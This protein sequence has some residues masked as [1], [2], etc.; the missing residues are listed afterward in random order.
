M[1]GRPLVNNPSANPSPTDSNRKT[2]GKVRDS[3]SF[4]S[5]LARPVARFSSG[6]DEGIGDFAL[7]GECRLQFGTAAL[8]PDVE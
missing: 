7:I 6:S 4:A 8:A 2:T 1:G 3:R 5:C